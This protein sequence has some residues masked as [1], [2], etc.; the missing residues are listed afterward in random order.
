MQKRALEPPGSAPTD[1]AAQPGAPG[2]PARGSPL[3]LGSRTGPA[4]S[5]KQE[6]PAACTGGQ[7]WGPRPA[8]PL[9]CL[10]S[11]RRRAANLRGARRKPGERADQGAWPPRAFTPAAVTGT[12]VQNGRH[13]LPN[14]SKPF[15][16]Q[17]SPHLMGLCSRGRERADG[18][19]VSGLPSLR[20]RGWAL[21]QCGGLPGRGAVCLSPR[22]P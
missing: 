4:A 18:H 12:G 22:P 3:F 6:R 10:C 7:R 2:E 15:P 21:A 20:S 13:R 19:R 16:S 9:G 14:W 17:G 1:E 11:A 5:A 8:A